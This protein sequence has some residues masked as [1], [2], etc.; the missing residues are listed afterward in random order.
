M[1]LLLL[2][3][4]LTL[5]YHLWDFF[6]WIHEYGLMIDWRR[7]DKK[8]HLKSF[9]QQQQKSGLILSCFSWALTHTHT[10]T[11]HLNVIEL[12]NLVVVVHICRFNSW[13]GST[14]CVAHIQ[15]CM[16]PINIDSAISTGI[17]FFLM[18][19]WRR[20][21]PAIYISIWM[22]IFNLVCTHLTSISQKWNFFLYHQKLL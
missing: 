16:D 9:W 2:K 3:L 1:P 21:L 14:M 8:I 10:H 5:R 6:F 12:S 4:L 22:Y 17:F 15:C 7:M 20:F 13:F 18:K 11:L 19:I